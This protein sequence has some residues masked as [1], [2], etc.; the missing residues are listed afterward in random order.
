MIFIGLKCFYNAGRVF[1]RSF[2][3]GGQFD[4]FYYGGRLFDRIL[5]VGRQ[6]DCFQ[7]VGRVF[8]RSL[9]V[10]RQFDCFK[11]VWSFS[12]LVW[13]SVVNSTVSKMFGRAVDRSFGCCSSAHDVFNRSL[14]VC[15]LQFI[16]FGSFY[17]LLRVVYT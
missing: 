13:L 12:T 11:L 10:G 5:V 1:D 3:V 4:C 15:P 2:V 8:D 17:S 6:F 9:V 16:F 14:A 7:N